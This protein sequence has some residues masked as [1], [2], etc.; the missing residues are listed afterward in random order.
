MA[1]RED[2]GEAPHPITP[3]KSRLHFSQ[4]GKASWYDMVMAR[5]QPKITRFWKRENKET[6]MDWEL[7]QR[8]QS[9]LVPLPVPPSHVRPQR[10]EGCSKADVE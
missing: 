10:W 4:Y 8:H 6:S 1:R 5:N 3:R 2:S 9:H 7:S